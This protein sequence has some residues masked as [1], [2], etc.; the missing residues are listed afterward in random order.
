MS[1]RRKRILFDQ[2]QNERGRLDS[3]YA[4][5]AD[6]LRDNDFDV[7]AYSEFMLIPKNLTGV[8][9]LVFGCPNSS[10][11]RPTEIDT[12]RRFVQEGGGLM[13]LSLSGGDKGLMNNMSMLS[14]DFGI[15]FEN[16]AAKDERNNAGIPTLLLVRDIIRHPA[17]E[18]VN[19]LLIP[20][21]C[22][23]RIS[24]G[25]TAI[26]TTSPTADPPKAPLIAVAEH[27]KGRV[28]CIGSYEVFR[29]GGGMKCE[30]N[31]VFAINAF[32]WLSADIRMA[33][34]SM[35]ASPHTRLEPSDRTTTATATATPVTP[36]PVVST[37]IEHAIKRL[38]NTVFDLQK[39][40][41]Q[42][43]GSVNQIGTN[44]EQLRGQFREFAEKIQQQLGVIIP[45]RQFV[46]EEEDKKTRLQEEIRGIEA[47]ISA[48]DRLSE[49][50]TQR[51]AAG[52]MPREA[53]EE[54]IQKLKTRR[55]ELVKR[56]ERKREEIEKK[57]EKS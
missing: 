12:I 17:I 28:M 32:R 30:D 53:Y 20:S 29:R 47:E 46:S 15:E 43:T 14:K 5:L 33:R 11:L 27:E 49:H 35:I 3:T 16:T 54:Q 25:A 39:S 55:E 57:A 51:H 7:E 24:G 4:Q 42:L 26:A 37:E 6:V 38:V 40:I 8:D 19:E 22:T 41:T 23:L 10:K 1:T 44:I 9:V 36:A 31:I 52:T 56:L 48:V 21:P 45:T 2:T 50:I 18:G 13:L 34:P